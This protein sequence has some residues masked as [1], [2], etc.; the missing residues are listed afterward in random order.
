MRPSWR[1]YQQQLRRDG[2]GRFLYGKH[3]LGLAVFVLTAVIWWIFANPWPDS[4]NRSTH[5][6]PQP[7]ETAPQLFSKADIRSLLA[8]YSF[9][10]IRGG[11]FKVAFGERNLQVESTIDADLQDYLQGK[12][13]RRTSRYVAIV[14]L[15]AQQGQVR[16]MVNFAREGR[17]ANPCLASDFP[18]ASLF[19]IVTAAAALEKCGYSSQTPLAFNGASHTLYKS[20][21]KNVR[22]RYTRNTTLE[23]A[24]AGSVNPVFGKIGRHCL[25][26]EKLQGYADRFGFNQPIPFELELPPSRTT[27][28]DEPY[29][30]AEISSGFNQQ[31]MISPLH[32]AMLA[33]VVPAEGRLVEPTIIRRV[34]D[35]NG[36]DLYRPQFRS[37]QAVS[38]ATARELSRLMRRTVSHGTARKIFRSKRRDKIL[39]QLTIGGKTGSI[40]TR[41]HDARYDWFVGFADGPKQADAIA[42]AVLVAHEKF[43]GRRAG[44]YA[45]MAIREYFRPRLARHSE[46]TNAKT[47]MKANP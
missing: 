34:T 11:P 19:K 44:E 1:R 10:D 20:Q 25:G 9:K 46:A 28:T 17:T 5:L 35:Q 30:W 21:L 4:E 6:P 14:V 26:R 42:V 13:Y 3:L 45:R 29:Q 15:E 38:P 27:I 40:D 43:I 41:N 22:N 24:F 37:S 18:A 23:K 47:G 8:D 7:A 31:T 16:A 36:V 12:L 32:G 2:R 39:S 33:A